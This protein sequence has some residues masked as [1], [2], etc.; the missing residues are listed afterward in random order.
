[1]VR[2]LPNHTHDRPALPC[3]GSRRHPSRGTP[4]VILAIAHDRPG[5][6]VHDRHH[7]RIAFERLCQTVRIHGLLGG[8]VR[9]P[10]A[11]SS[12]APEPLS[13]PLSVPFFYIG[14]VTQTKELC[15]SSRPRRTEPSGPALEQCPLPLVWNGRRDSN[16]RP[17]P[18]QGDRFRPFR[19][20]G[21]PEV[22]PCPP[23]FHPVH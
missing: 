2:E 8:T 10:V 15:T 18:W 17:S 4:V 19:S 22:R 21:L 3:R 5:R 11:G 9:R 13:L 20:G 7:W 1:M 14:M 6:W 23:S 16:G 12:R